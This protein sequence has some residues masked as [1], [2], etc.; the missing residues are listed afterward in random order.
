MWA[1]GAN[2]QQQQQQWALD[3]HAAAGGSGGVA[4]SAE[5]TGVMARSLMAGYRELQSVMDAVGTIML[6]H[7]ALKV[8]WLVGWWQ[9]F[10]VCSCW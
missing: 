8:G 6:Q 2:S 10:R 7:Q 3:P 1:G 9:G 4:A 5:A